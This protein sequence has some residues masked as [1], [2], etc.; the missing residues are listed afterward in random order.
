MCD[1]WSRG[2]QIIK[3]FVEMI[4]DV[5]FYLR[6]F[7]IYFREVLERMQ[8]QVPDKYILWI[9][10]TY[11]KKILWIWISCRSIYGLASGI[12]MGALIRP[13]VVLLL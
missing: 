6:T 13:L 1:D 7:G 11:T 9:W 10:I 4:A 2:I 8:G 3:R 12:L 5:Q